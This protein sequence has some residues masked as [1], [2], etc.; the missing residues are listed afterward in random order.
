MFQRKPAN[1]V[2]RLNKRDVDL[3]AR[4]LEIRQT[5]FKK[6]RLVPI[7]ASTITE[8]RHYVLVRDVAFGDCDSPAFF[9]NMRGRRFST[10]TLQATFSE[11]ARRADLRGTKGRG[12]TFHGLRHTFVV[13]RMVAW[14]RDG[15]DVQSLLP[16][17]AI[18]RPTISIDR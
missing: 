12:P 4:L 15:S 11:I 16:A 7:H 10:K 2:T 5:K 9:V 3:D 8:L 17:L 1:E 14:Y 13:N 18:F 6:D